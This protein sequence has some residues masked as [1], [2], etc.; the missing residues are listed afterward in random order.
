[1]VGLENVKMLLRKLDVRLDDCD[2]FNDLCQF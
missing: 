2:E 1:M